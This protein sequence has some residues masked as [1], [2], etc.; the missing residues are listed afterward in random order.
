MKARTAAVDH[1]ARR[2]D[3]AW[4]AAGGE[5]LTGAARRLGITRTALEKWCALH[6]PDLLAQLRAHEP[7]DHNH[8]LSRS[9]S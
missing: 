6:A 8:Q 9:R 4:M 7:T 3:V 5:G 2:E 1:C